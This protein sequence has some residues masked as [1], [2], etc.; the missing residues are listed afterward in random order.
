MA[1]DGWYDYTP[2]NQP[3][4]ISH[5]LK[6]W[7]CLGDSYDHR[8]EE[9]TQIPVAFARIRWLLLAWSH[10]KKMIQDNVT[11]GCIK[12]QCRCQWQINGVKL[13]HALLI[14][15]HHEQVFNQNQ[16]KNIKN[17]IQI[18]QSQSG[19]QNM[20][21]WFCCQVVIFLFL[22]KRNV[23]AFFPPKSFPRSEVIWAI[24]WCIPA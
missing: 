9:K 6:K 3:P 16:T 19:I 20:F 8:P 2:T 15:L 7:R 4:S 10:E 14:F 21:T 13:Q 1:K 12:F 23:T 24:C 22:S 18:L 11:P 5:P 17:M